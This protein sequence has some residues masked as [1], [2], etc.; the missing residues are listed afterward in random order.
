MSTLKTRIFEQK[1]FGP[2]K[3]VKSVS[4][5]RDPHEIIQRFQQLLVEADN[6]PR[7]TDDTSYKQFWLGLRKEGPEILGI[8]KAVLTELEKSIKAYSQAQTLVLQ[9]TQE[10]EELKNKDGADGVHGMMRK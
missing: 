5:E 8:T 7:A 9:L 2:A 1:K 3:T 6:F 10:L 4:K